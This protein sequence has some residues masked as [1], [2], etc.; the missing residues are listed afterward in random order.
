MLVNSFVRRSALLPLLILVAQPAWGWGKTG[1]RV[2]GDIAEDY[3]SPS[4]KAA[5]EA[6]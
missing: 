5:V 6:V 3:L 4:A 1:H 2:T